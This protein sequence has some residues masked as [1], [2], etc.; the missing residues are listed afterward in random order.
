MGINMGINITVVHRDLA[1]Y[2]SRR[3][4]VERLRQYGTIDVLSY[5]SDPP[6][7]A[8]RPDCLIAHE[9]QDDDVRLAKR[10]S[11]GPSRKT[12][13]IIFGGGVSAP[14]LVGDFGCGVSEYTFVTNAATFFK[15]WVRRGAFPGWDFLVGEPE[16]DYALEILHRLLPHA[17]GHPWQEPAVE[18]ESLHSFKKR[19]RDAEEADEVELRWIAAS[20]LYRHY[21]LS[22]PSDD[23]MQLLASLRDALLGI[24]PDGSDGL[25]GLLSRLRKTNEDHAGLAGRRPL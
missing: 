3:E 11:A 14:S 15:E 17:Y 8:Y 24:R 13:L 23:P 1:S 25:V 4:V 21:I 9:S 2:T 7:F 10:Y 5:I 22:E 20:D 12:P 18:W 19:Y 16:L 6:K